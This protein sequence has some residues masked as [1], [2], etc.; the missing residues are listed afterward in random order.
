MVSIAY[1]AGPAI[2]ATT[3]A[4]PAPATIMRSRREE[5]G[6]SST[7]PATS[8]TTSTTHR[9]QL[10]KSGV[11]PSSTNPQIAAVPT[12]T[13]RTARTQN[14]SRARQQTA[15]PPPTSAATAGASA[16]V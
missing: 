8:P 13:A 10:T 9:S 2:P 7:S 3:A 5:S 4:T 1:A 12:A 14:C 6:R 11:R 16:A 15:A